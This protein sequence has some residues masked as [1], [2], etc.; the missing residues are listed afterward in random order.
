MTGGCALILLSFDEICGLRNK[1]S[2]IGCKQID[3]W[4]MGNVF[5]NMQFEST[6]VE[7]NLNCWNM[8][9]FHLDEWYLA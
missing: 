3:V 8:S 5:K 6:D 2:A 4:L 1:C 7:W 9:L